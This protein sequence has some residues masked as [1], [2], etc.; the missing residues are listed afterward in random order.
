[1]KKYTLFFIVLCLAVTT[2][3]ACQKKQRQLC[4]Y[5]TEVEISCDYN[6]LPIHR[7]YT[8][9]QKMEAVL[10]YLRL[11]RPGKPPPQSPDT[12]DAAVF[13]IKVSLSDGQHRTYRQKDHRYFREA[14]SGWQSIE[15]E[16]ASWLYTVLR[17]YQSDL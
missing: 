7:R 15:P 1:M 6:G 10:L 14:E 8:E 5:V 2:L 9:N 3:C 16:K 4:R 13:E 12:I 11:L 17:H